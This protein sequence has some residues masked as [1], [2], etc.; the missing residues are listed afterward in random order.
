MQPVLDA[1]MST[2]QSEQALRSSLADRQ[3]GDQINRFTA[4]LVADFAHA[5]KTRDLRQPWPIEIGD[6]FGADSNAARLKAAMS[7]V[8]R[9][10]V[11]DIGR[12]PV[13]GS[14]HITGGEWSPKA[15]A[16]PAFNVR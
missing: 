10:K 12:R 5:C 16:I 6:S 4:N 2:R 13:V 15:S 8:V 3:G 11:I 9:L 7:L 14:I 1:P